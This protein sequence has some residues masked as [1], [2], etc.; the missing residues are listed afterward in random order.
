[1]KKVLFAILWV[2][3][4]VLLVLFVSVQTNLPIYVLLI[5]SLLLFGLFIAKIIKNIRCN[6]FIIDA[7]VMLLLFSAIFSWKIAVTVFVSGSQCCELSE[8]V[9]GLDSFEKVL[10]SFV[11]SLQT[12]SMDEDYTVYI[13]ATKKMASDLSGEKACFVMA[14]G[15]FAVLYEALAPIVG[16]AF[17]FDILLDIFPSVKLWARKFTKKDIYIFSELNNK[18]LCIAENILK[19]KKSANIIFTD[20]YCD[21]D[22]E[23]KNELINKAKSQSFICIKEDILAL[24]KTC[25]CLTKKACIILADKKEADSIHTLCE[26][27]KMDAEILAK[28][29]GKDIRI[30]TFFTDDT[31]SFIYS[32]ACKILGE[33]IKKDKK[34]N[35]FIRRVN[36]KQEYIYYILQKYP[37]YNS[38]RNNIK[39]PELKLNVSILGA[40][41]L[42]TSMF[43]NTTW[44]GQLSNV[45]LHINVAD[46][47]KTEEKF[48]SSINL[49]SPEIIKSSEE[50]NEILKICDDNY[51]PPYFNFGYHYGDIF[52]LSV[53]DIKFSNG[54]TLLDSDYVFIS[55]GSD[56]KNIS[57][58]EKV[59]RET[60]LN[61]KKPTIVCVVYDESVGTCLEYM[62]GI[63]FVSVASAADTY[64]SVFKEE[65]VLAKIYNKNY[66]SL[67]E[68]NAENIIIAKKEYNLDSDISRVIHLKYRA[69]SACRLSDVGDEI[70]S[71]S[72]EALLDEYLKILKG[73]KEKIKLFDSV[74]FNGDTKQYV[75]S[76]E[77]FKRSCEGTVSAN[78][79]WLEHRRWNAFLRSKKYRFT[80]SEM[81]K[82]L[83]KEKK[84]EKQHILMKTHHC[85]VECQNEYYCSILP[86]EKDDKLKD[87]YESEDRLDIKDNKYEFKRYDDPLLFDLGNEEVEKYIQ[88]LMQE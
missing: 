54:D 28:R 70:S 67:K 76:I 32:N 15:G 65:N 7:R 82:D 13:S 81:D 2:A 79:R 53:G 60:Y 24:Q 37:L 26:L 44:C 16:G 68:G 43:L 40:G 66:E 75:E 58:A 1:M 8:M 25:S 63:V 29:F 27:S 61:G 46:E 38:I 31:Y 56:N 52:G 47:G 86:D 77:S 45:S 78:L 12:F 22:D 48:L 11:H 69:F 84:E 6:Q 10:N 71:Y 72:D 9:A 64:E 85:L 51:A 41:V 88:R 59:Y 57:M 34:E 74:K 30:Y 36:W 19:E 73:E 33:K 18:T 35:I 17:I 50:G 5:L 80:D 23:E 83:S 20:V 14:A 87:K 39:D 62:D 3:A 49:I 21:E 55:L 4:F 42:G